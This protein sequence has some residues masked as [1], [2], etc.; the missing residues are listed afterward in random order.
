MK[1]DDIRRSLKDDMRRLLPDIV[2]AY[3]D[4]A[5][6]EPEIPTM[7]HIVTS[8]QTNVAMGMSEF[9][10]DESKIAYMETAAKLLADG[11]HIPIIVYLCAEAWR[12]TGLE[13]PPSQSS[14]RREVIVVFGQS[15]PGDTLTAQ[16]PI[17]R[18]GDEILPG[19]I[20]YLEGMASPLVATFWETYFN[21]HRD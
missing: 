11:G 14:D 19:A 6:G 8:D 10:D 2:E 18:N 17:I 7:L 3:T 16:M 4:M 12:A 9:Q 21:T 15:A 20:E 13:M 5:I 1:D